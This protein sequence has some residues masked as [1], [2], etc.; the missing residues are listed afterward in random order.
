MM[1]VCEELA[2]AA[3]VYKNS[4]QLSAFS[5]EKCLAKTVKM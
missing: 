5:K 1:G 3:P 2:T 4:C